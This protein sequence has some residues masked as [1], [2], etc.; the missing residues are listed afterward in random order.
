MD[1]FEHVDLEILKYQIIMRVH[2]ILLEHGFVLSQMLDTLILEHVL[3]TMVHVV[4][5]LVDEMSVDQTVVED[6]VDLVVEMKYVIEAHVNLLFL[7]V[8]LA[9]FIVMNSI[10]VQNR[11]ID[12]DAIL[13]LQL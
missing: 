5:H 11:I 6:P 3:I 4:L 7:H 1:Q 2:V 12:T 10:L 8:L 13:N 9:I